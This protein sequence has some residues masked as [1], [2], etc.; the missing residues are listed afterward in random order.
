MVIAF[1]V[2]GVPIPWKRAR[3]A[4]RHSYTDPLAAIFMDRVRAAARNAGVR[5]PAKAVP[6]RLTARFYRMDLDT[7]HPHFGD[8]SNL[9]KIVE[10]ALNGIIWT[11]DRWIVQY[12]PGGKFTGTSRTE[13][14][15]EELGDTE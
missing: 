14:T 5:G 2:P 9:I 1:T 6:F 13:I 3:R 10:D 12:G 15:I 11:D 4:P 8:L 7:W